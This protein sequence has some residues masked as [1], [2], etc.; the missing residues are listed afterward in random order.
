MNFSGR[1]AK[2]KEDKH[3]KAYGKSLD[4][5]VKKEDKYYSKVGKKAAKK[6]GY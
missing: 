1:K 4:K 2:K 3:Y 6:S 5:Q